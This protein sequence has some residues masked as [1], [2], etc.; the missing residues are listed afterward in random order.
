[1]PL[2]NIISFKG[3]FFSDDILNFLD[4]LKNNSKNNKFCIVYSNNPI[5]GVN[6][7]ISYCV[8]HKIQYDILEEKII[9][10]FWKNYLIIM[11]WYFFHNLLRH[12]LNYWQKQNS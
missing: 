10:L 12:F 7:S 8:E 11:D 4:T 3:S 5:K 9:I 6:E 2:A 1:L